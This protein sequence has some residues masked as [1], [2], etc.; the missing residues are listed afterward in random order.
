MIAPIPDNESER[1]AA[2]KGFDIL[3]T[4]PE[5]AFDRITRTVTAFLDVPIALVSLVDESRQW[6]KS[7][8]GLDAGETPRDVAFCA[9][10]ILDDQVLV[11][12]DAAKDKRFADNPLVTG[13]PN[14]RFYAGAPLCTKDGFRL[15]TL[16][17]IDYAP[18]ELTKTQEQVLSDLAQVVVDEMELRIAAK[19]AI[20]ETAARQRIEDAYRESE[21]RYRDMTEAGSDWVW[22]MGPDLRF[23][24]FS[25]S[26]LPIAGVEPAAL[27]GKSRSDLAAASESPEKWEKHLDDLDNHRSFR[28]FQYELVRPDGTTQHIKVNGKSIFDE[29]GKFLGY[30]GTGTNVTAQV[31]AERR[32]KKAQTLLSDAVESIPSMVL[33]LDAD[34]RFVLCNNEYW[35]TMA[36][37]GDMLAP[38][39][40]FADICRVSAERG[41][42]KG[43]QDDP[44]EW[45]R[46]RMARVH[47]PGGPVVHQQRDGRWVAI[48]DHKTK[49]GGTFIIRTDITELKRAQQELQTAHDEL[50]HRVEERARELKESE[51]RL[52]AVFDNTPVCMNLK[53]TE[54]RYL[55]INK[56]Y[57][58]WFDLAAEDI[59]GKKASEFLENAT[60]VENLT[61]AERAVLE[62][63]EASER[64]VRVLRDDG[65]V[66]D[67]ILIKY[68][69]KSAEGSVQ[70]IGT[71]AVDITERRQAERRLR[72]VAEAVSAASGEKLFDHLTEAV[73][74][75]LEA[76]YAFIGELRDDE[77]SSIRTTSFFAD[78]KTA[79]NFEYD[80]AGTPCENVVDKT[81]CVYDRDIQKKFPEDSGLKTLGVESYVGIPLFGAEQEPL[82]IIVAM[83]RKPL[84]DPEKATDLLKIFAIRA[85]AELERKRAESALRESQELLQNLLDHSPA[86]IAIRDTAGR[87]RLINR[88]FEEAFGVTDD[89]LRGKHIRDL[90][91]NGFA[92]D[93]SEY[94]RKVIE[95]GK[96]MIHEHPADL[97]RGGDRL[98]TARFPIRNDAGNIVAVG[99]IATDI[100]EIRHT[101]ETLRE[102]EKQYQAVV[103]DQTEMISRHAPDGTRTFVNQSYCRYHGKTKKQLIGRSAYDGLTADDL[104]RLKAVYKSLTPE[105]PTGEYE[106]AVPGPD[107][108]T[109][110]QLWTKRAIFDEDGQVTEYQAV[111]RDVSDRKRAEA[112]LQAALTEAEQANRAKSEFL[113]TI[114]HELRTPLNAI[115]GF[116]EMLVGQVFGELGS[117]KYEEYAEDIRASSTHL[118][119]LVNDILDLSA[120][121]AGEFQLKK[122]SLAIKEIAEDCSRFIV[123]TAGS[124]GIRYAL[125]VPE[126]LPPLRVDRRAV[127]QILLNLL[128]NAIKFTPEGGRVTLK[129]AASNG[130]HTIKVS[131]TGQGIAAEKLPG[132]TKPFVRGETDPH[133]SQEGTGLGLAIVA[134]LVDFHDGELDIK[135]KVGKG[136]TVTVTLPNGAP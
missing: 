30:R 86:I 119:H 33:L 118:L 85:A 9:H 83:S 43:M 57:E 12:E 106:I 90:M 104:K 123:K 78:G 39:T 4:P 125:S 82:G 114:S 127:K 73:V 105:N 14:I 7:R 69:V 91:P 56:P 100:T 97:K 136:T 71:V 76:D 46:I 28:D 60:E 49:N 109:V 89:A 120:I 18:R 129:A 70:A 96:P 19:K 26:F 5:E 65:K 124:K 36:E 103:E 35:K 133:K 45:V 16:C 13:E 48:Q 75:V 131:D 55:L 122:E 11:V 40:P 51:A 61:S 101:E 52:R 67:R 47:N 115:N 102:V 108:E 72:A 93:L 24:Y 88:A 2:L 87:F 92:K 31:E 95:S 111:G 121:E 113:A 117:Q 25:E 29:A 135:S 107:G 132:L 8:H 62:T 20:E 1:L 3:D 64:E 32:A 74:H 128:S 23:T 42:V 94:D 53:D 112:L 17:A 130:R 21:A 126:N 37:I 22:E 54:G 38:G 41:L 50:E 63:G 134:S 66:F 99:S 6:F 84:D 15:G 116:S 27:I 10:A 59:I 77:K 44:E 58:E 68:P 80:L 110:W 98:L 79:E 34:D 81:T